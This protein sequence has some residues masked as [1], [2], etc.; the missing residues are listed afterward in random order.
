MVY[1]IAVNISGRIHLT[2]ADTE[3]ILHAVHLGITVVSMNEGIC[4]TLGHVSIQAM[5][6]CNAQLPVHTT[7]SI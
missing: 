4:F 6:S 3:Y 7:F 2:D 5:S 1:E